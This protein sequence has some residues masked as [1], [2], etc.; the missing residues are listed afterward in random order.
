MRKYTFIKRKKAKPKPEGR[1]PRTGVKK[2][3]CL[4]CGK[5]RPEKNMIYLVANDVYVCNDECRNLFRIQVEKNG[6]K[7]DY[8][9]YIRRRKK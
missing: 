6:G 3:K 1:N 7:Y 2:P 4:G 9:E 5:Q 8:S